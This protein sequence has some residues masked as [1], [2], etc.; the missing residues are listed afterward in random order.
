MAF[1]SKSSKIYAT[2]AP[3]ALLLTSLTPT[4]TANQPP[5]A[6][7]QSLT[8]G[9]RACYVELVNENGQTSTEFASF[10]ICEQ[11][12]V[13]KQVRLT[14]ESGNILAASCHT[15]ILSR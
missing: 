13:G 14:Y 9:D 3:S 10:D 1:F 7:V 6:T 8:A 15:S 11:D 4:A 12:L 2:V 5:V